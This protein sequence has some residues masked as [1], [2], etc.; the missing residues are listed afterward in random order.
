MQRADVHFAAVRRDTVYFDAL[1]DHRPARGAPACALTGPGIIDLAT[2][3]HV[4]AER[5]R[6]SGSRSILAAMLFPIGA[7]GLAIIF[8]ALTGTLDFGA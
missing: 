1:L 6:V 3:P 2:Q 8:A 5:N 7:L 4:V